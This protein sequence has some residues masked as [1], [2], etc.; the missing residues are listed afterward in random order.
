M[1][2]AGMSG[3]QWDR[4]R[5]LPSR[6]LGLRGREL[7]IRNRLEAEFYPARQSDRMEASSRAE[8]KHE[9]AQ[10]DVRQRLMGVGYVDGR[11]PDGV[12]DSIPPDRV[13]RHPAVLAARNERDAALATRQSREDEQINAR[14]IQKL[15]QAFE[16]IKQRAMSAVA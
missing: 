15:L 11:M 3:G 9:Q 5:G 7:A 13:G 10:A 12:F 2:A 16:Q 14:E 6:R 1:N 4:L 8:I